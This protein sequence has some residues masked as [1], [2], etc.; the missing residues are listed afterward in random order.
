LIEVVDEDD[1]VVLLLFPLEVVLQDVL[2]Q[3]DSLL[4][5]VNRL[6]LVNLL[7]HLGHFL[8][9]EELVN[10][11]LSV[12]PVTDEE[13]E[14]VH[15]LRLL[16][17]DLVTELHDHSVRLDVIKEREWNRFLVSFLIDCLLEDLGKTIPPSTELFG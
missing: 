10:W 11:A 9:V 5:L 14:L 15:D 4:N 13:A 16:L 1:V 17:D 7:L 3:N 2:D 12:G 6:V 8:L